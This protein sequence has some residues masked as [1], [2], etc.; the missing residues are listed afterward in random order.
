MIARTGGAAWFLARS[1]TAPRSFPNLGTPRDIRF[2][3]LGQFDPGLFV[4]GTVYLAISRGGDSVENPRDTQ[5]PEGGYRKRS[6]APKEPANAGSFGGRGGDIALS[7]SE[8]L[9]DIEL[10]QSGTSLF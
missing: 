9:G 3:G 7:R 6:L 2:I 5:A 1:A 4:F 10:A 8:P